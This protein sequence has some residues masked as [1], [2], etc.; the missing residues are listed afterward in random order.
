MN[1]AQLL[2]NA[3]DDELVRLD[4]TARRSWPSGSF[5]ATDPFLDAAVSSLHGSGYARENAIQRLAA[6][7]DGRELRYLLLRLNDW[8]PQVREAAR[9]AI[10]ARID[11]RYANHFAA[12]L[13]LV[14]RLQR[15]TRA[16]H[17]YVLRAVSQMLRAASPAGLLM[18][19]ND[20]N[21]A[22]RRAVFHILTDREPRD[23]E[24]VRAAL[25]VDD[26]VIRMRALRMLPFDENR[27][28][29]E[30]LFDDPASVVRAEALMLAADTPRLLAALL[31]RNA[32]VR[33]IVR[34][35]LRE[36]NID[37]AALYRDALQGEQGKAAI[38]GLSETGTRADAELLLPFL[39]HPAP[40]VRRAAV[41]A[42]VVL[43]RDAYVD[44]V[45]QSLRDEA[46]GVSRQARLALMP[47]AATIAASDIAAMYEST[48]ATHVRRNL[49]LLLR[50]MSKWDNITIFLRAMRDTDEASEFA[51]ESVRSWNA[52]F[53][54]R[55]S[56]PTARQLEALAAA[57]EGAP[58]DEPTR[59][60]I[61]FSTRAFA[62]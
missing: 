19:L 49:L 33:A 38:A 23:P 30:A 55:S 50:A 52:E 34:I 56:V 40:S 44:V 25:R 26:P 9:M 62:P 27:A 47:H 45:M 46:P 1:P 28:Q 2:E 43:G 18:A 58:L 8:V 5:R 10:L 29:I 20:R 48:Q 51:E 59:N 57:L 22:T 21:A 11:P 12:H 32:N 13:G 37:F 61:R 17:A 24:I 15:S 39:Q 36:Q 3:T 53:N 31:D 41:R 6:F 16:D 42:I 60:A 14:T 7:R 4:E 35:R 54:R